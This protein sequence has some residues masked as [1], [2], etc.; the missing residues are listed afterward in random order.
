MGGAGPNIGAPPQWLRDAQERVL[1]AF[2]RFVLIVALLCVITVIQYP[3][4]ATG[5]ITMFLLFGI[6]LLLRR[7]GRLRELTVFLLA[8]S[9][10]VG[11]L[12]SLLI[13]VHLAG[14]LIED[15]MPGLAVMALPLLEAAISGSRRTAWITFAAVVAATAAFLT[16][17]PW[18]QGIGHNLRCRRDCPGGRGIC[19]MVRP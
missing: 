6:A 12:T 19:A 16:F 3:P 5:Y 14:G 9:L 8:M 10:V 2:A 17:T 1:S 13:A 4:N 15:D 18:S 11:I 7:S